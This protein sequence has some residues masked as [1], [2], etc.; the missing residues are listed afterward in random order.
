LGAS[1]GIHEIESQQVGG[2]FTRSEGYEAYPERVLTS[3][4][5]LQ[6]LRRVLK[7]ALMLNF[8]DPQDY[9][10]AISVKDIKFTR[11]IRGRALSRDEIASLIDVCLIDLNSA[12]GCRDAALIGILRGGG[13]RREEA[14]NLEYKDLNVADGE[15]KIR[16]GKG[17]KDRT[18]YLPPLLLSLVKDWLRIRGSSKGA[19]LCHIRKGGAVVVRS[20]TPQSSGSSW[21]KERS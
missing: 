7:E 15:L 5:P 1:D 20:L 9:Q 3:V 17:G 14:V 21:K 13:L 10:K 12:M 2:L 6:A 8:I 19:L 11:E 16:C 4:S 18:V